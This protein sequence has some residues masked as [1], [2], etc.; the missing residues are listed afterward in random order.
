M[1]RTGTRRGWFYLSMDHLMLRWIID[2][3]KTN[4]FFSV[5]NVAYYLGWG[6]ANHIGSWRWSVAIFA[7]DLSFFLQMRT[8]RRWN[9]SR[10]VSISSG[11]LGRDIP[12]SFI[13]KRPRR[14]RKF[15]LK[16]FGCYQTIFVRAMVWWYLVWT[17]LSLRVCSFR[18]RMYF[19]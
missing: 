19:I 14:I 9:T 1:I 12:K 4:Q 18:I 7:N 13:L 11:W 6:I 3:L 15:V 2:S 10:C 17:S 5:V 16:K 8:Y